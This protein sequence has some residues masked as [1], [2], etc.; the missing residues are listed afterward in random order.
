MRVLALL[1]DDVKSP[2]GGVASHFSELRPRGVSYVV[3]PLADLSE[4]LFSD[5]DVDQSLASA[6]LAQLGMV[7]NALSLNQDFDIIHAYDS[8][9]AVA[10]LELAR[11]TRKPLVFTM[12]LS[13]NFVKHYYSR[14]VRQMM[15]GLIAPELCILN[16]ADAVIHVSPEYYRHFREMNSNTYLVPNSINL[17]RWKRQA[18]FELPGR[19]TAF[20][21]GYIGRYA[22]MKNIPALVGATYPDNVDMYF[23]GDDN[24]GQRDLF[25]MMQSKVERTP[26]CYYLGKLLGQNKI[27]WFHEMDAIIVPSTHEPFGIVCLEALA[28]GCRLMSSF[29]SGMGYYLNPEV[30]FNCGMTAESLTE[31]FQ[32]VQN[33]EPNKNAVSALLNMFTPDAMSELTRRVYVNVLSRVRCSVA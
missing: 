2:L 7:A 5:H 11:V 26:N 33:W 27:D 28:S 13:I 30:A 1:P 6:L 29:A 17:S 10:G 25:D 21:I 4:Y 22:E 23:V 9:C 14:T 32:T 12:Q 19:P 31:A 16:K 24:G 15:A 3:V 18:K 8:S 20:K